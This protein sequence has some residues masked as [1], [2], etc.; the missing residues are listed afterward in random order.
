MDK[1]NSILLA[2]IAS[3]GVFLASSSPDD[4]DTAAPPVVAVVDYGAIIWRMDQ[5]RVYS[6]SD[7]GMT[8]P[9]FTDGQT[10]KL[11]KTLAQI[12]QNVQE[13]MDE[14]KLS[15]VLRLDSLPDRQKGRVDFP[16]EKLFMPK[17]E[18]NRTEVNRLLRKRIVHQRKLDL[19]SLVIDRLSAERGW[20]K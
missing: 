8:I 18:Y 5:I 6:E 1:L 4:A 14:H 19:T 7:Q 10:E 3:T 11:M 9:E 17:N 12:Q 16:I 2:V 20:N 15:I 13:L